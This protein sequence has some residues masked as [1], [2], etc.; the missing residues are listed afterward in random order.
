M[1][2]AGKDIVANVEAAPDAQAPYE[3]LYQLHYPRVVR[4]CRVL[5]ADAH[6]ADDVA[7]EVFLRLW[8]ALQTETRAVAWPPWLTRVTV[9]ACRDRRRSG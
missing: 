7:Q 1:E 6:E 8:Q 4:L 3:Q 9:N 2:G 5:L